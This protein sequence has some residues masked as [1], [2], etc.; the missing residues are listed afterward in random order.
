MKNIFFVFI[1]AISTLNA[2]GV[3]IGTTNPTHN[4]EVVGNVKLSDE[5]YFENPGVY[6]DVASNSYLIVRDNSDK[7]LKRYVPA[8]AEYSAINSTVFYI[9]NIN[10]GG[11]TDFNTGISANDYYLVI[12]GFIIRG[13]NNNSNI[14]ITQPANTNLNE[15]IPQYSARSYIQ[16]GTWHIK[17]TPNNNRVF[18]QSP[19]IRLNVS[20]YRRDMLTTINNTINYNMNGVTTGVASAPAPVLP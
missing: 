16:N 3:G 12:G 13:V 9:K 1:F 14:N 15:F 2:Q 10:A 20:V 4:L 11:L 8:T 6:S 17:F 18:D 7:V 5:L 19:E